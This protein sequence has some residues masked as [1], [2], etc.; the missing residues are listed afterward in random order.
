MKNKIIP[1]SVLAL[2][3]FAPFNVMAHRVNVFAYAEGENIHIEGYFVDGSPSRDSK[4]VVYSTDGAAIAEGT[5]NSEGMLEVAVKN[6]QTKFGDLKIVLEASMGHR[7]EY[8]LASSEI[9][10]KK[11]P[12]NKM[13]KTQTLR[14]QERGHAHETDQDRVSENLDSSALEETMERIVRAQLKPVNE[15][16]RQ[17]RQAAERPGLTQIVGGLGYIV[18]LAGAYMWGMSRK[19]VK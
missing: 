6:L 15:S 1:L 18:G 10:S 7:G 3:F 4:V 9:G 19:A 13:E 16:L 11:G 17:L 12:E 5:T 8:V 14:L 2:L